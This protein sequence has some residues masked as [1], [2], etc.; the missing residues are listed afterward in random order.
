MKGAIDKPPAETFLVDVGCSLGGVVAH[1]HG[2][3]YKA[4]GVDLNADYIAYSQR[5]HGL[6]LRQGTLATLDLERTPDTVAYCQVFEHVLDPVAELEALARIDGPETCV[7]IE[8]PGIRNLFWGGNHMDFLRLLQNAHV[9][10]FSQRSLTNLCRRAGWVRVVGDERVRSLFRF[11]PRLNRNVFENDYADALAWLAMS[12]RL[13]KLY[14]SALM[15]WA[16]HV[17]R[18]CSKALGR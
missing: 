5:I 6:D 18:S 10:H 16:S 15:R 11:D 2:V 4:M 17:V 12:E 3:G 14:P 8:V 9:W 13:R 1:F 7:Y